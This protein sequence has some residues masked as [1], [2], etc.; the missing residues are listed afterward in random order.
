MAVQVAAVLGGGGCAAGPPARMAEE[1]HLPGLLRR[2]PGP[3]E[4]QLS[5][6]APWPGCLWETAWR[7]AS[8]AGTPR[9][10]PCTAA[11]GGGGGG[12]GCWVGCSPLLRAPWT[13]PPDSIPISFMTLGGLTLRRPVPTGP[14]R[15]GQ[16]RGASRW[17]GSS[18][19]CWECFRQGAGTASSNPKGGSREWHR[20]GPPG[21]APLEHVGAGFRSGSQP[22]F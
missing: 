2:L 14:G 17:Q 5:A 10:R 6:S 11:V 16:A 7:A 19:T 9:R 15:P 22:L 12:G 21:S 4:P 20:Q 3:G 13:T 8:A 18:W 1:G